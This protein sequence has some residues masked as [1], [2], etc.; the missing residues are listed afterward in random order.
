ME[1]NVMKAYAAVKDGTEIF[2][3]TTATTEAVAMRRFLEMC[4]YRVPDG[5]GD[6]AVREKFFDYAQGRVKI[7]PVEVVYA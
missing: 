7:E 4:N 5:M 3:N 2:I 6:F 1:D